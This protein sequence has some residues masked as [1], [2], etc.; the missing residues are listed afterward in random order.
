MGVAKELQ[1]E[2][3]D[4][5]LR[6]PRP[7]TLKGTIKNRV[8]AGATFLTLLGAY[9]GPNGKQETEIVQAAYAQ[10]QQQGQPPVQVR[11]YSRPENVYGGATWYNPAYF[12]YGFNTALLQNFPHPLYTNGRFVGFYSNNIFTPLASVGLVPQN[13]I[14]GSVAH[15]PYGTYGSF[16]ISWTP[17]P[18]HEEPKERRVTEEDAE[19]II[20]DLLDEYAADF[21]LQPDQKI[22]QANVPQ[23][24]GRVIDIF[25]PK[26]RDS[27]GMEIQPI[28]IRVARPGQKLKGDVKK[29]RFE[30]KYF[31]E[32]ERLYR[33][34]GFH[35]LAFKVEGDTTHQDVTRWFNARVVPYLKPDIA[36]LLEHSRY[37]YIVED[38]G[39][40]GS[41]AKPVPTMS[42]A[43]VLKARQDEQRR[44]EDERRE[45]EAAEKLAKE[46]RKKKKSDT[47]K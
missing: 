46:Q 3:Y 37:G 7:A 4:A 9:F 1:N 15:G 36:A 47:K 25:V 22:Y 21:E 23:R 2:L 27:R 24:N 34:L 14:Y 13:Y 29:E 39:D 31:E 35:Y 44:L 41:V 5:S 33:S 17:Q 30:E 19:D 18:K 26:R 28:I 11:I 42:S 40:D 32:E 8:A 43:A 16:G 38:L 20:R 12:R 10:G 45:R 6:F